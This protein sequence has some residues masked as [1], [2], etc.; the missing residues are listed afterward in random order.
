VGNSV[1]GVV[2]S[3]VGPVVGSSVGNSDGKSVGAW[4]TMGLSGRG[5]AQVTR[6][7]HAPW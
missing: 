4:E 1:G 7:V 2:G 3:V 6:M 5:E